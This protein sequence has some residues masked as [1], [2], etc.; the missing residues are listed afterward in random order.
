[1]GTCMLKGSIPTEI[2]FLT[3]LSY[4][5]VLFVIATELICLCSDILEKI[6]LLV[7]FQLNSVT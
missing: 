4:L 3:G 1:M 6:N 2:G 5:C 7:R